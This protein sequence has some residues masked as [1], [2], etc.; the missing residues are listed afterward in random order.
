M[1][2][3]R[4]VLNIGCGH[5]AYGTDR[6]DIYRTKAATLICDVEHG[7]PYRDEVFDEVY[8][9]CLF[10]HLRNPF[11]FL[12]EVRRVLKK[13][14]MVRLI[15]DNAGFW[16]FYLY[17]PGINMGIH[18]GTYP[19]RSW[20]RHYALYTL[21]HI[22]NHFEAGDLKIVTIKYLNE[23]QKSRLI[24]ILDGLLGNTPFF[25]HMAYRRIHVEAV[26]E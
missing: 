18:V 10:E 26:K 20:D 14:G 4:R 6:I 5:D 1:S 12:Q 2:S 22:K 15:T 11:L 8:S 24:R 25:K 9:K 3:A 13:R 17:V 16:R 7:L 21:E 19:S 23:G